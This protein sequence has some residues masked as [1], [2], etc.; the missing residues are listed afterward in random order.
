M[1]RVPQTLEWALLSSPL[2]LDEFRRQAQSSLT[3]GWHNR[4]ASDYPSTKKLQ[5]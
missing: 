5:S 3:Q 1:L 4:T 2:L